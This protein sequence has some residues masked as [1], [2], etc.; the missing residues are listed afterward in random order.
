[1]SAAARKNGD[2]QTINQFALLLHAVPRMGDRTISRVLRAALTRGFTADEFLN[3]NGEIWRNDF[4]LDNKSIEFLAA[5]QHALPSLA[6]EQARLLRNLDVEL[7]TC[8]SATYPHR[9]E[10]FD[11]D[12]P[13]IFYTRGMLQL[14]SP[15]VGSFTFTAAVS[16]GHNKNALERQEELVNSLIGAGGIPIT[17]HD[18][19]SYQRLA[20]AAQRLGKPCL[21]VLDRG[22]LEA[23]GPSCSLPLFAAARIRDEVFAHQ[24]DLVISPFR[25][26]DHCVGGNNVRR[27]RLIMALSQVVLAVDISTEGGML[28]HCRTA[29]RAGIPVLADT[30]GRDGCKQLV[31]E[32]ATAATHC[33]DGITRQVFDLLKAVN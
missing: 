2:P 4:Q 24:R 5:N 27:D 20:L 30:R 17:G 14:L 33:S 8:Q 12:M 22:I 10:E 23:M 9:I 1:M 6:F 16:R 13:P 21:Y 26:N 19:P 32:G 28:E 7:I 29:I 15:D 3:M 11:D 18:R 31:D 25:L